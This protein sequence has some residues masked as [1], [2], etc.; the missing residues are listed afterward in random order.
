[1]NIR[2]CLA[3]AGV[4]LLLTSQSVAESITTE[5]PSVSDTIRQVAVGSGRWESSREAAGKNDWQ[6]EVERFTDDSIAGSIIVIGSPYLSKAR[7]EGRVDGKEVYGV[8]IGDD[9]RQVGTFSGIVA[10]NGVSGT[11]TTKQGDS[12]SWSWAGP[13][14]ARTLKEETTTKET[15]DSGVPGGE[16]DASAPAP[17]N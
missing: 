17:L 11:Y 4:H 5:P 10:D 2:A 12:G 16:P 6:I 13:A 9:E 8:L 15:Y 3:V 1:M 14:G 7:I